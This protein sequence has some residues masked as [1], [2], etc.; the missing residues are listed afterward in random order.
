[1]FFNP[2][3]LCRAFENFELASTADDLLHTL[4]LKFNRLLDALKQEASEKQRLKRAN[5]ELES[6]IRSYKDY[7][8][9]ISKVEMQREIENLKAR[10]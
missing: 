3:D 8:E 9:T 6:K 10:C 4:T 5:I 7:R 1:M 2:E